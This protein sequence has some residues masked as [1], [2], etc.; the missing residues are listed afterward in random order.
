MRS[1]V[2]AEILRAQKTAG[3]NPTW[4]GHG[5]ATRGYSRVWGGFQQRGPEEAQW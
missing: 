5:R 2:M 4:G 1:A 3:H